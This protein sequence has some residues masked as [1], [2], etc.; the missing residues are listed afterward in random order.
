MC[1]Y[2]ELV[3]TIET[4]TLKLDLSNY[5]TG[6]EVKKQQLLMHHILLK[7]LILIS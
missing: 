5:V 7:K 3:V 6:S 2:P 1:Y 4:K